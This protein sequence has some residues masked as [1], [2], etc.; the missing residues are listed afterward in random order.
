MLLAELVDQQQVRH[1]NEPE[2]TSHVLA[3]A[4][5]ASR[6]G[7]R[8]RLTQPPDGRPMDGAAAL[9]MAVWI[10]FNPPVDERRVAPGIDLWESS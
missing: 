9:A 5:R 8:W 10:V 4:S 3:A 1:A 7:R 6:F 2:L